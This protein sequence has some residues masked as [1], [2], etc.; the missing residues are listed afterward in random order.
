MA[1]GFRD[2]DVAAGGQG[3]PLVPAFHAQVFATGHRRAVLNLGGIANFS[4][5]PAHDDPHTPVTGFDCGPGN[6]LLDL[7]IQRH[8]GQVHDE[9][10][11]WGAGGQVRPALLQALLDEPFLALPPPKSTGRDLFHGP[12]L[13]ARLTLA[14]LGDAAA[15]RQ[16]AQD[17]QATLAEFTAQTAAD[18]LIRAWAPPHGAASGGDVLVCGGGAYNGDLMARLARRLPGIPVASTATQGLPPLQVEAAA[19]AW[20]AGALWHGLPGNR[21]EVTGARGLRVLGQWTPA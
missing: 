17:V 1:S 9:D 14:G 13:Q 2:R 5:L 11:R 18:A 21:P 7:W 20:L 19:F 16:A 6:V 12:W 4:L 8:R 15:Q 10:G 3:A